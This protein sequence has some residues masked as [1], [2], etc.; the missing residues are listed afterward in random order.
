MPITVASIGLGAAFLSLA[1]YLTDRN[2]AETSG[3]MDIQSDFDG[4]TRS[5]VGRR[6]VVFLSW[7]V[8]TLLVVWVAGVLPAILLLIVLYMRIEGSEPWKLIVPTAATMVIGAYVL[9]DELLSI[10]WPRTLLGDW[11]PALKG[12]IPSV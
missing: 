12:V 9:F 5:D 10:V 11:I 4:I 3:Y 2:T 1:Y 7:I 6:A 8:S